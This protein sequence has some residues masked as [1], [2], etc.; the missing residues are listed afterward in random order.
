[1]Y[2]VP[3]HHQSSAGSRGSERGAQW[4]PVA[5]HPAA[6]IGKSRRRKEDYHL[7]TGRTTWTDNMTLPGMLHLAILR[8]PMAHATITSIDTTE[9]KGRPGV[10]AVFTGQDFAETQGNLPC[11]WPVTP[12]MVNPGAPSLA[13]TQVNHVGEAV[14][15][16]AAR[17]K[18]AAQDALEG[19]DVEYEPLPAIMN[20]EAALEEGSPLVHPNTTSN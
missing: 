14:A 8:S 4:S 16:V 6:W 11:A 17:T 18:A 2:R 19:I 1:M 10:V 12:D 5:E 3:E 15:G 13:V 20:M 9:A 7:I